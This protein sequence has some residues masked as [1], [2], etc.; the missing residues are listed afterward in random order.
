MEGFNAYKDRAYA[1][2]RDEWKKIVRTIGPRAATD[3]ILEPILLRGEDPA[4]DRFFLFS[5]L[6]APGGEARYEAKLLSEYSA[7]RRGSSGKRAKSL[8]KKAM[9]TWK[10]KRPSKPITTGLTT[11]SGLTV[12]HTRRKPRSAE[13]MPKKGNSIMISRS[14]SDVIHSPVVVW[15]QSREEPLT[16][17]F[18][19]DLARELKE[20]HR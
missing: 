6:R 18:L 2:D 1:L 12:G 4:K 9:R 10:R 3:M 19:A 5:Q 20:N 15:A 7:L 17:R 13:K 8:L 14:G 16:P 11:I